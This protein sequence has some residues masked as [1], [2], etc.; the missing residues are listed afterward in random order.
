[1]DEYCDQ[2][3][4]TPTKDIHKASC[5]S[6]DGQ[7]MNLIYHTLTDRRRATSII[8]ITTYRE[9][10]YDSEHYLVKGMYRERIKKEAA[11]HEGT[12]EN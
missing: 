10:N 8:H 11:L 12:R 1:M 3:D 6:L 5:I 7:T 2:I 4:S 9:S